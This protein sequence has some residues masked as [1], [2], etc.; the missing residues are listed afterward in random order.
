MMGE[1]G[2][3]HS[4]APYTLIRAAIE[5]SAT[6]LW[7]LEPASPNEIARRS[8]QLEYVDLTD[9]Q[10]AHETVNPGGDYDEP[11]LKIFDDCLSR[12]GWKPS[13]IKLRPKGSLNVIKAAS[14]RFDVPAA[15]LMWQMCSAAA[16]G[17]R[18]SR[19]F[20]NLFEGEDNGESKVLTGRIVSDE[21]AIAVVLH[22]AC[23]LVRKLRTVR[24]AHSKNPL[25]SG[26]SFTRSDPGLRI[27]RTGLYLPRR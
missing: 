22:T 18:W 3:Q 1:S 12:H 11:R 14:T 10:K 16:H 8:L 20:L 13:D 26:T 24:D 6:G 9:L 5:N 4:F 19:D 27:A 17:R 15:P 2:A 21:K 25:H 7:I 23:A